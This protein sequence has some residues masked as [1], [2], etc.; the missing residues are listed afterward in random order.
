MDTKGNINAF[1]RSETMAYIKRVE[2]IEPSP[3]YLV[4]ISKASRPQHYIW[5]PM[6][7]ANFA[8]GGIVVD[9]ECMA[10][11]GVTV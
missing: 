11:R 10:S 5:L 2:R 6:Y 1:P 9:A 8:G 7:E 3:K 4:V